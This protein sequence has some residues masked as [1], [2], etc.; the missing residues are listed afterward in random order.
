VKSSLPD[1]NILLAVV[2]EG[3]THHRSAREWFGTRADESVAICRVTQMGLLRLLTNPK[4]L[5]SGVCSIQRA[6]DISNEIL[7]DKRVFFES[8]P[9]GLETAWAAMMQHPAARSSSW[10]DA[11]L[12]AFA[13]QHNYE[14]VTFDRDFQRWVDLTI[15]VLT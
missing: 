12:A 15:S 9:L 4:V 8:E 2:A 3:H 14:M 6:W 5:P 13:Q 11:Y 10:T 7:A 1:V